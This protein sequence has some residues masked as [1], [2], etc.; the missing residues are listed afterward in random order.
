M[1]TL[2]SILATGMF[3][4][5]AFWLSGAAAPVLPPV[6]QSDEGV[7]VAMDY[8]SRNLTI[9]SAECGQ[10]VVFFWND[11]TR[12]V[13]GGQKVL[14]ESFE[15]GMEVRMFYRIESGRNMLREVTWQKDPMFA[16]L[17]RRR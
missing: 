11:S 13:R 7:I 10:R 15:V 6:Q 17:A 8:G 16:H 3:L 4:A 1:K 9:M 12:F 5:V 2:K 14:A